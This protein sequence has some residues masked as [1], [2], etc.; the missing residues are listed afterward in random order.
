M[1]QKIYRFDSIQELQ[2]SVDKKIKDLNDKIDLIFMPGMFDLGVIMLLFVICFIIH[3]QQ[4]R[5][6]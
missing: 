3:T 2:E 5:S 6:F 1:N 4:L